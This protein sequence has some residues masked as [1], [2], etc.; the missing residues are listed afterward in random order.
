M[1]GTIAKLD[2]KQSFY[3]NALRTNGLQGVC[4]WKKKEFVEIFAVYG[5]NFK[6]RFATQS[7]NALLRFAILQCENL[8]YERGGYETFTKKCVD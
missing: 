2:N 6:Y 7:P 5:Y 1:G 3:T 4:N 8:F